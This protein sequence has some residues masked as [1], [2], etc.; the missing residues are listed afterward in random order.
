MTDYRLFEQQLTRLGVDPKPLNRALA[1][2]DEL[3]KRLVQARRDLAAL[4]P[5]TAKNFNEESQRV[6]NMVNALETSLNGARDDLN[7]VCDDL[8]DKAISNAPNLAPLSERMGQIDVE[9]IDLLLRV[10]DLLIERTTCA[11][12]LNGLHGVVLTWRKERGAPDIG[13]GY[14]NLPGG[15]QPPSGWV[16]TIKFYLNRF[17]AMLVTTPPEPGKELEWFSRRVW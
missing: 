5:S 12:S 4:R 16:D 14:Y 11:D 8:K 3:D 9:V 6:V 7:S 13:A 1:D 15:A 2:V 17:S 10:R